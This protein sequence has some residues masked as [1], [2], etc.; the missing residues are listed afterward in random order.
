MRAEAT[1][2]LVLS[3]LIAACKAAP[4]HA[5][6]A[7]AD[8]HPD[9]QACAGCHM[10]AFRAARNDVHTRQG[11]NPCGVCHSQDAWH[12]SVMSHPWPLTG[13]HAK[14]LCSKCHQGEPPKFKGTSKDCVSCH[15]KDYDKA[16][17]HVAKKFSTKCEQCHQT[18]EWADRLGVPVKP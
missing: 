11:E 6:D 9:P 17:N 15:R 14:A 4:E 2:M 3:L 1:A 18:D 10:D 8:P 16:P 12:P 5:S 13:A 7:H